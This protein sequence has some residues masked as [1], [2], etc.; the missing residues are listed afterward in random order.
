[1]SLSPYSSLG[2]GVAITATPDART[3][4]LISA[5]SLVPSQ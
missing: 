2:H 1:M 5:S 4:E 3:G